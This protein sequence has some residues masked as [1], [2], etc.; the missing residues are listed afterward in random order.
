MDY[1]T[2]YLADKQRF[3]NRGGYPLHYIKLLRL[4]QFSNGI[5]RKIYSI[6]LHQMTLRYGL[7]I[8]WTCKIGKGFYLG[9]AF[10]ITVSPQAEIGE[11][12]NLHKGVTIGKQNRGK[13]KGAPKIGNKV[14]IGVNATVVGKVVIG[15]DVLIAPGA[16][17]NC[18]VPSHSVVIGNPCQIH[19]KENATEGYINNCE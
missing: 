8:P 6:L 2:T 13:L 19:H 11:W 16:Y 10:C 17:V 7:E 4:C 5:A 14:W 1:K 18:D 12:C 9:H 15:D 3:G